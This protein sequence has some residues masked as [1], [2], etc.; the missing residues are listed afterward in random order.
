MIGNEITV[1]LEEL[2][3]L[4]EYFPDDAEILREAKA[5]LQKPQ[6]KI[7]SSTTQVEQDESDRDFATAMAKLFDA[8]ITSTVSYQAKSSLSSS[9]IPSDR[10]QEIQK[11]SKRDAVDL[12]GWHRSK[13]RA[14]QTGLTIVAPAL[15]QLRKEI[16]GNVPKFHMVGHSFGALLVASSASGLKDNEKY[17]SMT[18]LQGAFSHNAF[19]EDYAFSGNPGAGMFHNILKNGSIL[20]PLVATHTSNDGALGRSL[21]LVWL[22]TNRARAFE[23]NGR[24]I[25]G[26]PRPAPVTPFA[27]KRLDDGPTNPDDE[28]GAIGAKVHKIQKGRSVT[29]HPPMAGVCFRKSSTMCRDMRVVGGGGAGL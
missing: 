26:S 20:G 2:D 25:P 1:L 13:T 15:R 6:L 11:L 27:A 5:A 29:C 10:I 28:Y 21:G 9:S 14:A 19:S 16:R 24:I 23:E 4:I 22:Y 12:F 18:L 8:G 17:S 3:E 7:S